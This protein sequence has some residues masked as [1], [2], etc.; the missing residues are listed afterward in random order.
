MVLETA[1]HVPD[2]LTV[3]ILMQ[4]VLK[5][6]LNQRGLS[7]FP[8]TGHLHKDQYSFISYLTPV[9]F[10][11]LCGI[12]LSCFLMSLQCGDL[13]YGSSGIALCDQKGN[14]VQLG[15]QGGSTGSFQTSVDDRVQIVMIVK[16]PLMQPNGLEYPFDLNDNK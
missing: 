13:G 14:Y 4:S 5:I 15:N 2:K 9:S 16:K 3:S 1:S 12:I 7:L 11:S 8:W 6:M 10:L